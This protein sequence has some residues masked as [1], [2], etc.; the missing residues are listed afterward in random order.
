MARTLQLSPLPHD[1][2]TEHSP[3][4]PE[5]PPV[6]SCGPFPLAKRDMI[7]DQLPPSKRQPTESQPTESQP[8]RPQFNL[9]VLLLVVTGICVV[10]AATVQFQNAAVLFIPGGLLALLLVRDRW[11]LTV[12]GLYGAILFVMIVPL[13]AV[14]FWHWP[15]GFWALYGVWPF[16]VWFDVII[17][18]QAA[19]LVIPVAK[20]QRRP[21]RHSTLL[22]P[23]VVAG[24]MA[25]LL[26]LSAVL[27]IWEFVT[28][29]P[30]GAGLWALLAG[31]TVWIAWTVVFYVASRGRDP[32]AVIATQCRLLLRGSILELL[33]AV[34]THIVAR[35]RDYCCAGLMT[36]L[37]LVFGL[38]VMLFSFG[39]AIFFLFAARWKQVRPRSDSK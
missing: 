18:A 8:D 2:Y 6:L 12:V 17:V 13:I 33:I 26:V 30:F 14:A 29:E 35:H 10:M 9:K 38:S 1:G 11:A 24:L 28:R 7:D 20:I 15:D 4:F 37:G 22:K 34:P 21:V 5:T 32:N 27:A 16:W 23:L 25:G 19:L 36:F 3:P 31:L 39:P